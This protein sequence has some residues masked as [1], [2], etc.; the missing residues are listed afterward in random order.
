[1]TPRYVGGGL[2]EARTTL[3]WRRSGLSVIAV[4]LAIARGIPTIDSVPGRPGVGIAVVVL[5]AMAFAVSG[6]QAAVRASRFDAGRPVVR[7]RE[8]VPVTMATALVALGAMVVVL[9]E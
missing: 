3:A 5:G 1:M 2:A 9:L 8:L 7:L 4:G 6:R